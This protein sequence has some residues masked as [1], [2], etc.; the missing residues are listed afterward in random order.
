[1]NGPNLIGLTG[2]VISGCA[3]IPQIIHLIKERCSAGLS[4]N[5]FAL[6][7]ISSILITIN[8]LYIHAVVFIILGFIQMLST[9]IIFLYTMRYKG[10]VCIFH[11]TQYKTSMIPAKSKP[12]ER[13]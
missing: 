4:R 10:Q 1:M 11:A 6:W 7:F 5:A 12:D 2:A 3:Y 13:R 9:A 8:A